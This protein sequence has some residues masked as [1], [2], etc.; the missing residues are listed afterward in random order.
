[1]LNKKEFALG[2][3]ALILGIVIPVLFPAIPKPVAAALAALGICLIIY[4][5]RGF[6]F[7]RPAVRVE[8][9]KYGVAPSAYQRE[10]LHV[11]TVGGAAF[12]VEAEPVELRD[13]W[14]LRFE[15]SLSRIEGEAFF[16]AIIQRDSVLAFHLLEIWATLTLSGELPASFPLVVR[17]R[18]AE[19]K[20][21][22]AICEIRR[23]NRI[24]PSGFDVRLLK[25][26]RFHN[27]SKRAR[28]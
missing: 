5:V 17:Y 16:T 18:D 23:D 28:G 11:K 20:A 7:G 27:S 3:G 15:E 13:G 4:A 1:M 25:F 10:G 14:Q 26:R 2:V 21:W 6:A 19:H 9:L 22:K 12:D 8:P 24:S